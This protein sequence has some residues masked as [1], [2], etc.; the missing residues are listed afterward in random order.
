[1]RCDQ[2]HIDGRF[3]SSPLYS[4][5]NV[6]CDAIRV[7]ANARRR[8]PRSDV[9][10]HTGAKTSIPSCLLGIDKKGTHQ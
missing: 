10:S 7:T 9:G 2:K 5:S 3:V 8:G 1:M 4:I 6:Q